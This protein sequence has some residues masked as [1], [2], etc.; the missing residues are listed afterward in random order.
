MNEPA[1]SAMAIARWFVA[2]ASGDQA[3]LS[4][5]KLQKLLYYAQGN[6]LGREKRPLFGEDLQAWAHGPVVPG[7]YRYFKEFGSGDLQLEDADDFEWEQ[8]DESTT[9][10]L[11]EVWNTY[12]QF[13]AWRLRNMTHNEAPWIS[14]FRDDESHIVIPKAD[15]LRH[16]ASCA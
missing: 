9:Q 16:F 12:G 6:W 5:L 11:I 13:G 7:V 8:I 15:L 3:D 10:F 2:W 14:N 4:N 1:Y